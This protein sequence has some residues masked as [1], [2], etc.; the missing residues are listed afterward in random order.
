VADI[1]NYTEGASSFKPSA[2]SL[3]L[4]SRIYCTPARAGMI[5]RCWTTIAC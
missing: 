5:G 3:L 2:S 1:T 4:T